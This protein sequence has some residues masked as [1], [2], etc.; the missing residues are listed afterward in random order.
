MSQPEIVEYCSKNCSDEDTFQYGTRPKKKTRGGLRR[1]FIERIKNG[2]SIQEIVL[3]GDVDIL[4]AFVGAHRGLTVLSNLLVRPRTPSD[5]LQVIWIYGPPGFG[6]SRLVYH[7][8]QYRCAGSY[9]ASDKNLKWFQNYHGQTLMVI[10]DFRV[11]DCDLNELLRIFDVLP[12]RRENKGSSV[13]IN[14]KLIFV[15]CPYPPSELKSRAAAQGIKGYADEDLQQL[16]RRIDFI[17][18]FSKQSDRTQCLLWMCSFP[19]YDRKGKILPL[20]PGS[21]RPFGPIDWVD[22]VDPSDNDADGDEPSV[23]SSS[24]SSSEEQ[25]QPQRVLYEGEDDC[26]ADVFLRRLLREDDDYYPSCSQH[27]FERERESMDATVCR[28]SGSH[29]SGH[30]SFEEPDASTIVDGQLGISDRDGPGTFHRSLSTSDLSFSLDD[31]QELAA[32]QHFDCDDDDPRLLPSSHSASQPSDSLRL[33]GPSNDPS[34]SSSLKPSFSSPSIVPSSHAPSFF[35]TDYEYFVDV[36]EKKDPRSP[37]NAV[38]REREEYFSRNSFKR[39]KGKGAPKKSLLQKRTDSMRSKY[40]TV[41]KPEIGRLPSETRRSMSSTQGSLGS[42]LS[43]PVVIVISSSSSSSSGEE[44]GSASASTG[45]VRPAIRTFPLEGHP[46]KVIPDEKERNLSDS[47]PLPPIRNAFPGLPSD[48]QAR[49]RFINL[50]PVRCTPADPVRIRPTYAPVTAVKREIKKE[51]PRLPARSSMA[52]DDEKK[53]KQKKSIVISLLTP[54][55][56]KCKYSSASASLPSCKRKRRRRMSADV[57]S[58][59]G[60]K[61]KIRKVDA[62]VDARLKDAEDDKT[63][64]KKPKDGKNIETTVDSDSR[65]KDSSTVVK[66]KKKVKKSVDLDSSEERSPS[67]EPDSYDMEF[68]SD[69]EGYK[70]EEDFDARKAE[71]ELSTDVSVSY[72][73]SDDNGES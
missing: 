44:I 11:Q 4:S 36:A 54:E 41:K 14:S 12:N 13:D 39:L 57:S 6:K 63:D 5:D 23:P 3:N 40:P 61:N 29:R 32:S 7:F 15:T 71:A 2:E 27:E 45:A 68:L 72:N 8:G 58:S 66:K 21:H 59:E 26:T 43:T 25:R 42:K 31:S 46:I 9:W 62:T 69:V 65:S 49:K 50:I 24:S 18:D 1:Q 34:S 70:P 16:L 73:S 17:Y 33:T 51:P 38:L 22:P 19:G 35:G 10:E 55:D 60:R 47:S 67:S 52:R 37:Y 53:K 28:G 20:V 48:P 64:S 30:G 56:L